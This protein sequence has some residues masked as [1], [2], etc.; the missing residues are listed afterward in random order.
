MNQRTIDNFPIA[1][2]L[3]QWATTVQASDLTEGSMG[4]AIFAAAE[5]GDI[6]MESCGHIIHQ[7]VAAGVDSTI[8]TLGNAWRTSGPNPTSTS[9]CARTRR[10]SRR[11]STR[12]CATR[13]RS[14]PSG[15]S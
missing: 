15:D 1:G 9:C 13:A 7:Y 3:F 12:S 11:R 14:M 8:A 5:R 4:R 6:P 10:S 2:E